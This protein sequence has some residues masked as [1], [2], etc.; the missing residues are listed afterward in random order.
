MFF[1]GCRIYHCYHFLGGYA[2][3]KERYKEI[4]DLLGRMSCFVFSLDRKFFKQL[5]DR[6]NDDTG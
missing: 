1:V 2:D 3:Q 4:S 6:V 5:E